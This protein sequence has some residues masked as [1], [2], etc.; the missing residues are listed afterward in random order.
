[1]FNSTKIEPRI[2]NGSKRTF[3]VDEEDFEDIY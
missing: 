2:E 3:F 1:M